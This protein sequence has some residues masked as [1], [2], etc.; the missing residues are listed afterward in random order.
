MGEGLL[1]AATLPDAITFAV[2]ADEAKGASVRARAAITHEVE[3]DAGEPDHSG[4]DHGGAEGS[5]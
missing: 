4:S 5:D 2:A 1:A 3:P